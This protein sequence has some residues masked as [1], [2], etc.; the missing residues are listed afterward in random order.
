M[1]SDYA[2]IHHFVVSFVFVFWNLRRIRKHESKSNNAS[3]AFPWC[4][5][6]DDVRIPSTGIFLGSATSQTDRQTIKQLNDSLIVFFYLCS[7]LD[8]E[9][10]VKNSQIFV[11][12]SYCDGVPLEEDHDTFYG[13]FHWD[14]EMANQ[15]HH[16]F[17]HLNKR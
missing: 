9:T 6:W 3:S 10:E 7:F 8:V 14:G 4:F 15:H 16:N 5:G 1:L 17:N 2:D 12:P 13:L 11:P